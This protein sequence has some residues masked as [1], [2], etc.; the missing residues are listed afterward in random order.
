MREEKPTNQELVNKAIALLR[1]GLAPFV[2]RE[3]KINVREVPPNR[4]RRMASDPKLEQTPIDK[5]DVQALAG[6]MEATWDPVFRKTLGRLERS[7]VNE[8][9]EWRNWWA[10][11]RDFSTED[12][13]RVLDSAERLLKSIEAPQADEVGRIRRELRSGDLAAGSASNR[14]DRTTADNNPDDV[15][16]SPEDVLRK[17]RSERHQSWKN[18]RKAVRAL[19]DQPHESFRTPNVAAS[20]KSTV[21]L[22]QRGTGLPLDRL[23]AMLDSM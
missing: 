21:R 22:M 16:R 18:L 7:W 3:L 6:I 1:D 9:R 19:M 11:Q 2:A 10:H 8:L 14:A 17:I 5:W 12:A 15:A 4:L 23:K 13:E 20:S